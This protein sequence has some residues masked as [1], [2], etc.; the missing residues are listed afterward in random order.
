MR[1]N[2]LE[3]F[4]ALVFPVTCAICKCS[5]YAFEDYLCR[6]CEANL[7]VT[8]YHFVPESNDLKIKILGLAEVD[9]V[10]A[11]LKYSKKGVSQQLLHQLKYNNKPGLGKVL[12]RLYGRLLAEYGYKESWDGITAVPLH[13]QKLRRRGYNQSECF[14]EGLEESL[15]IPLLHALKRNINTATQTRKSRFQR[16]ENVSDVFE[17]SDEG[18]VSGKRILL[19][20]DVMTTGA[21]L[22]SCAQVIRRGGPQ[23]VDLAVIAAGKS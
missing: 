2:L 11:Y 16:W 23:C 15:S 19:V 18:L 20:D 9:K 7:P 5:L 10:M 1:F 4:L 6:K 21:T 3:D 13:R 17:L 8:S 22:A 12:G 14:A